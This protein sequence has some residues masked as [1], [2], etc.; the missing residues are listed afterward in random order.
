M[1]K[2]NGTLML[3]NLDGVAIAH[4]TSATLN[5]DVDLFD[6]TNKGSGGWDENDHG[7][8]S[9]SIDVDGLVDYSTGLNIGGL[10]DMILQREDAVMLFS[11]GVIGH[12]EFS[13]TVRLA[14]LSLTAD[15]EDAVSFSG[16]LTGSG[17]LT[18]STVT[19]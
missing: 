10:M 12:E 14:S 9:W 6:T 3:V 4:T 19:T 18:K 17:Q 7:R 8:R 2:I 15:Q 16:S 13:G 1:S 5:I 11:S